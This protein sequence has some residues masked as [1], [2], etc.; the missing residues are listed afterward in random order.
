MNR[1]T[2]LLLA[3]LL[4]ITSYISGAAQTRNSAQAPRRTAR[5]SLR[6]DSKPREPEEAFNT[7]ASS[8]GPNFKGNDERVIYNAIISS[9]YLARKNEFETSAAYERRLAAFSTASLTGRINPSSTLSS[10]SVRTII[11]FLVSTLG[12][13]QTEVCFF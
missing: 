3:S 1:P 9:K 10:L 12:T 13:T 7:S 2:R 11:G 5:G 4:T 6:K 8:L